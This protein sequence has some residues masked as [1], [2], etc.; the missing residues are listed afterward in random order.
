MCTRVVGEGTGGAEQFYDGSMQHSY[1]S[2]ALLY[3]HG[4]PWCCRLVAQDV[5]N[6]ASLFGN[7]DFA[8]ALQWVD[9][10]NPVMYSVASG[11]CS[12]RSCPSGSFYC[13]ACA[14]FDIPPSNTKAPSTANYKPPEIPSST[15]ASASAHT[16]G[17]ATFQPAS[18]NS[19]T[20]NGSSSSSS[21]TPGSSGSSAISSSATSHF[22]DSPDSTTSYGMMSSSSMQ[23]HISS[24]L[25]MEAEQKLA[26]EAVQ[27]VQQQPHAEVEEEEEAEE[28]V[29]EVPM[30][31]VGMLDRASRLSF[32]AL[33]MLPQ[34]SAN[35]SALGCWEHRLNARLKD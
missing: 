7:R 27:E 23:H 5:S 28:Q 13:S 6:L 11:G 33:Q 1:M 20:N 30:C 19:G 35:V 12:M 17:P 15:S 25:L 9:E 32:A 3:N 26:Q 22:Y 24:K 8:D 31:P 29:T 14:N 2:H 18:H 4:Q 10:A 21:N 34:A 16:T